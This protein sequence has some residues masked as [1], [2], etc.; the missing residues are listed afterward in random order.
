ML[1]SSAIGGED[2]HL[3]EREHMGWEG[4]GDRTTDRWQHGNTDGERDLA[5]HEYAVAEIIYSF[6]IDFV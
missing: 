3:G 4:V 2:A 1:E 5:Y 6:L